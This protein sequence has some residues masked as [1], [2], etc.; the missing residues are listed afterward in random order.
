MG[1]PP[2][3]IVFAGGHLKMS[4]M[5]KAGF[6]LNIIAILLAAGMVRWLVPLIIPAG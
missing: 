1:T 2:N 3:A 6:W 5:V 4:D